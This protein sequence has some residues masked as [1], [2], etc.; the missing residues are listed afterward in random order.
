MKE[1][2]ILFS[3][4]MVR[5]IL[6]GTKTQTR[7]IVKPQP[8]EGH[9]WAGWC[10]CSTDLADEGKAVFAVSREPYLRDAHRVRCPYGCEPLGVGGGVSEGE[11]MNVTAIACPDGR[12]AIQFSIYSSVGY[13]GMSGLTVADLEH[14]AEVA[15][16]QANRQREE[17]R[18]RAITQGE[19]E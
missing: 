9:V 10:V 15:T 13:F 3:G 12:G 11:A 18:A 17:E 4:A 1:R 6:G 7:R 14:I 16:E 19:C 8:P 2:P 5:A